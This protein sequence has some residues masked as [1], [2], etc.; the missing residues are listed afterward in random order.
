MYRS[1]HVT[2]VDVP[3]YGIGQPI[4]Q[5][6]VQVQ[7]EGDEVEGMFLEWRQ[8]QVIID[9]QLSPRFIEGLERKA[10]E[11]ACEDAWSM[12]AESAY[13]LQDDVNDRFD[14]VAE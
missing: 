10:E 8:P 1:S 12:V 4:A 7:I 9:E 14:C 3:I 5:A 13:Y 2:Y 11:L 6:R